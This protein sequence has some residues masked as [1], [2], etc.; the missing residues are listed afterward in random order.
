M[1]RPANSADIAAIAALH[2]DSWRRNYR[3]ALSD[4]FLD[5]P[6]ESERTQR[7]TARLAPPDSGAATTV[8]I[9][10]EGALAGFVH[11]IFDEDAVDGALLEN[12]HVRHDIKRSG[13]GTQLMAASAAAVLGR[14]TPTGLYLTVLVQNTPAQAFYEARGG[15]RVGEE[16]WN[17]PDGS[18]ATR[19]FRYAWPDP[20]VLL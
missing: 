12:L 15:K 8:A 18:G 5:G 11:T 4:D 16:P 7:W 9:D 13:L 17:A 20:A 1:L 6:I 10:A 3:G 19:V 14:P 2:T